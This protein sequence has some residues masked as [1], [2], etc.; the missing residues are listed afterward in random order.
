MR[1]VLFS[2]ILATLTLFLFTGKSVLAYSS[3][4][5]PTGYVNDFA[6]MLKPETK[7]TLE[8]TLTNFTKETS[9]EISV[10]T[11][12]NLDGDSI[13]NYANEL[14]REWGIGTK[15]N[16]NGVLL[17]ISK[18]DR[19]LRIEVGYGLEGALPDATAFSIITNDI[20]PLFK[21]G[22]YDAGVTIGVEKIISATK[23]EY[24]AEPQKK[25]GISGNVLEV[26]FFVFIF[27]FNILVSILAPSKSWWLGGVI[28]GV[29]GGIV[30]FIF[31]S[32]VGGA[33]LGGI[34]LGLG[35]LVDFFVSKAY[36]K[37]GGRG[38]PFGGIWT[39]G[40]FGSG[41]SGGGFGGFSGGSSGGGGSSGSW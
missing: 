40:G 33:I 5:S 35:L 30:G 29:I 34:L 6:G 9:S 16:N 15:T 4:G 32:L 2:T 12:N 28:G 11:V 25:K 3:P 41:S 20:T 23:G 26:L 36:Q 39:G 13:E 14:F 17:L 19:K 38:G 7:T 31:W 1:R 18:D 22:D 8:E 10:V 37:G 24:T 21:A 27:G